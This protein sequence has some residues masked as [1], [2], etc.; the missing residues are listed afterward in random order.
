MGLYL[1]IFDGDEDV[2]GVDVGSYADYN[3]LRDYVVHELES[4]KAGSKFPTFIL[5][6]DSDG[7]WSAGDCEKLRSE[8]AE[9][10]AALRARPAIKLVSEW[11]R[12]VAKS[13]GLVPQD[14]FE[15]FIDVDGEF[16]LERLQ[17]LVDGALKRQ[18]PILFQ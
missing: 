3:A 5:H 4:G 18:L 8:L 15:S 6:S 13:I 11:Q 1:C 7:E 9:I 2:D 12:A 10:A 14:A 17:N 16:L